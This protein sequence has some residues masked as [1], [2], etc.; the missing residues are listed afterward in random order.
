MLLRLVKIG[1]VLC[2]LISLSGALWLKNHIDHYG[3]NQINLSEP[4][5]FD[6]ERG[7]GF[8]R[9]VNQLYDLGLIDSPLKMRLYARFKEGSHAIK[10]GEYRLV[11]GQ[12]YD[13]LLDRFSK[14]L[15]VQRQI[16]LVEGLRLSDY[17]NS[18]AS[19]PQLEQTLHGKS[20][21]EIADLLGY[22]G[23][24]P[25][26]WIFPDTYSFTKGSSDLQIL[27]WAYQRMQKVLDE[28]WADRAEDLPV[29]TAYEAL[30]L[31]SIVEKETGA[32]EERGEIA[33]VFS[34][35]LE[36][37]MRLQTDPT[38]IYGMGDRYQGNIRR[39]DLNRLTPYNTYR[40]TGLPPTPIASPGREAIHASLHPAAGK[41]LY[42]VAKGDGRHY[43]S[44]TL[45]EHNKAVYRYQMKR[46][47]DYRSSISSD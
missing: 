4:M 23:D 41:T 37:N 34:R 17:L 3:E 21:K 19:E 35:R 16:T 33:G 5:L 31:A 32:A 29:K 11:P 40:I 43:F 22:K 7:T 12:S 6:I 39:S 47:D 45:E 30:I 14:G 2:L 42:F 13:E 9:L 46:R 10:S 18:L 26:G 38:V 8:L 1:F 28:E 24:N 44:T 15:V 25:E 27:Q 20:Y 36:K